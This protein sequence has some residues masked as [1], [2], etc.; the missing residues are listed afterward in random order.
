M[1]IDLSRRISVSRE[2]LKNDHVENLGGAALLKESGYGLP[3]VGRASS[4][5]VVKAS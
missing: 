1:P 5:T 4:Q 3:S 2:K